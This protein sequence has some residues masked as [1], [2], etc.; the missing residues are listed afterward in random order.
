MKLYIFPSVDL[1]T[2]SYHSAGGAV[3]LASDLEAAVATLR[4]RGA[5]PSEEEIALAREFHL[6]GAVKEYGPDSYLFP[7]SGCC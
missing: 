7:Y 4:L 6:D 1:L 5:H 2:D 3:V